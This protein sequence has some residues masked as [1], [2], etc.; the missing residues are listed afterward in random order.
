[1]SATRCARA[2]GFS[3]IEM[4]LAL[5]IFALLL[6]T[7]QA[8]LFTGHRLLTSLTRRAD[9]AADVL[10][11]RRVFDRWIG[12]LTVISAA[13][14]PSRPVA[15]GSRDR[16]SFFASLD[17]PSRGFELWAVEMAVVPGP[18]GRATRLQMSRRRVDSA[19]P[20]EVSTLLDWPEPI[21]FNYAYGGAETR[22]KWTDA[23]ASA[24]GLPSEVRLMAGAGPLATGRIHLQDNGRC[25]S[26]RQVQAYLHAECRLQ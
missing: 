26:A 17:G 23:V 13:P 5:G 6:A 19:D 10:V 16:F 25:V 21:F 3:L 18:N 22:L 11:V 2:R 4:I 24:D 7:V 9:P 12:A 8:S 14:D 20:T 15:V 1:M